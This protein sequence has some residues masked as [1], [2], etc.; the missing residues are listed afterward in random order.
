[1]WSAR[2]HAVGQTDAFLFILSHVLSRSR[3][4]TLCALL[5]LEAE[6]ELS[7]KTQ[8]A[9]VRAGIDIPF[10]SPRH[11]VAYVGCVTRVEGN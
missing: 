7:L 2:S 8:G 9:F 10:G 3:A 11:D 4:S 1:M 5:V 6:M